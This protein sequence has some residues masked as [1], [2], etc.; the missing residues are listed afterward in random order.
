M[1]EN[2]S[3][4]RIVEAFHL[5]GR[6]CS[7]DP[8]WGMV[9]DLAT[10][11]YGHLDFRHDGELWLVN[12]A[13]GS[14]YSGDSVERSNFQVLLELAEEKGLLGKGLWEVYGGFGSYGIVVSADVEDEE[15]LDLL[16]GLEEYPVADEDHLAHLEIELEDEAWSSWAESDFVRALAR[17]HGGYV[18]DWDGE[19]LRGVFEDARERANEYWVSES[20]GSQWID[21]GRVAAA[22]T[23]DEYL[24]ACQVDFED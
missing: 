20:G 10:I 21:L 13:G 23:R 11:P 8:Y 22:T 12:W 2:T 9:E 17:E 4:R 7:L 5:N 6:W 18:E 1:T 14:D 15:I 19:K 3:L 24:A 16:A